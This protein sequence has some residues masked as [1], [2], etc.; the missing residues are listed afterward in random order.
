MLRWLVVLEA[1][2]SSLGHR[3]PETLSCSVAIMKYD[4]M[5]LKVEI[6]GRRW[7]P[8]PIQSRE[9]LHENFDTH[10]KMTDVHASKVKTT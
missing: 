9:Y 8:N 4:G 1:W 6:I 2:D 5:G 3:P 7:S 10:L